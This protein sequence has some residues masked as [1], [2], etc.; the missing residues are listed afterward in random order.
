MSQQNIA[1]K[2]AQVKKGTLHVGV[3]LGLGNNVAIV[4]NEYAERL[5]R[6]RFP[7]DREGYE[8]FHRHIEKAQNKV[9]RQKF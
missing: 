3:D 8:Y 1:R 4:I 7:N 2:L 6:F 5:G 9:A